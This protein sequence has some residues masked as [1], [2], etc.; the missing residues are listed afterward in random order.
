MTIRRVAAN[1]LG[2]FL[3]LLESPGIQAGEIEWDLLSY[4]NDRNL[5]QHT[6]VTHYR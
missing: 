5:S 6:T 4:L 2:L 1:R 3:S